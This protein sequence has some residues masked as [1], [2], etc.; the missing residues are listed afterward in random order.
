MYR[1]A[2]KPY[3]ALAASDCSVGR[4]IVAAEL[5]RLSRLWTADHS[6]SSGGNPYDALLADI[7]PKVRCACAHALID[8]CENEPGVSGARLLNALDD[9]LLDS[10][11]ATGRTDAQGCDLGSDEDIRNRLISGPCFGSW[12]GTILLTRVT[13]MQGT[14]QSGARTQTW[15]DET[16]EVY[17][18][19][20][21]RVSKH[22]VF[23]SGG[24]PAKSWTLDTQGP[25]H[26]GYRVHHVIIDD[27]PDGEIVSTTSETAAAA[28]SVPDQGDIVLR[29]VDGRFDAVGAGG[30][31]SPRNMPY[32]KRTETRYRCKVPF[33]PNNPCPPPNEY[34]NSSSLSIYQG[35]SVDASDTQTSATVTPRS[36][37]LTWSRVRFFEQS[38]G[39][40]KRVEERIQMSLFRAPN[41]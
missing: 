34:S 30:G 20:V 5:D 15:D 26:L 2:V 21:T 24:K 14:G 19:T 6:G 36:V 39:P 32:T 12:T 18:A 17:S 1:D 28:Q 22:T 13:T 10:R 25:F 8:R 11:L 33:P 41:R 29:L 38:F 3:E 7:M 4:A 27:P 31:A 16:R 37:Q 35:Y 23:T 9:L 40:P